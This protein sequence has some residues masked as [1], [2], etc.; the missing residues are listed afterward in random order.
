MSESTGPRVGLPSGE[1]GSATGGAE[2]KSMGLSGVAK[3]QATEVAKRPR[4]PR[5]E[6]DAEAALG[7]PFVALAEAASTSPAARTA[8]EPTPG[9]GFGFGFFLG[10]TPSFAVALGEVFSSFFFLFSSLVFGVGEGEGFGLGLGLGLALGF[11]SGVTVVA[12]SGVG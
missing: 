11:F 9:L 6:R 3:R 12:A 1:G 7:R 4:R 8:R 2:G 5:T 10:L